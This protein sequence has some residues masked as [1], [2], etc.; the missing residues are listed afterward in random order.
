M[1]CKHEECE[2][3]CQGFCNNRHEPCPIT[4]TND[5][6]VNTSKMDFENNIITYKDLSILKNSAVKH[7]SDAC[8]AL[9][10]MVNLVERH[11]EEENW[12]KREQKEREKYE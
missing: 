7:S 3:N 9:L 11:L 12:Q 5:Q 8:D 6:F 2:Y 10:I 4:S 1:R